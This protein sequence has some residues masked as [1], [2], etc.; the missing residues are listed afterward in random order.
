M[1]EK[2]ASVLEGMFDNMGDIS[3]LDEADNLQDKLQKQGYVIVPVVS[4]DK[5]G[6]LNMAQIYNE[7]TIK[8]SA[9][10]LHQ[11]L[12]EHYGVTQSEMY[13][14]EDGAAKVG[15]HYHIDFVQLTVG[16]FE[17]NND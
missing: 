6:G 14:V 1:R 16:T 8:V 17:N 5:G 10:E 2:I 9:E 4:S 11:L 7:K 13:F 15:T 3:W 12:D